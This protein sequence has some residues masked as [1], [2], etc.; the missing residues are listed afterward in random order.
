MSGSPPRLKFLILSLVVLALL[1]LSL[2][3]LLE[4]RPGGVVCGD[5]PLCYGRFLPV[6][7]QE[8]FHEMAHRLLAALLVVGTI[9]LGW[10]ARELSPRQ[11][12]MPLFWVVVQA[13]L[14][15][16][17]FS[18]R[19]PTVVTLLHLMLVPVFWYSL[20][21]LYYSLGTRPSHSF[22][23]HTK[24]IPLIMIVLV[25]F[26]FFLG[27][28]LQKTGASADILSG[29]ARALL[30]S[31]RWWAILTA[32]SICG[33]WVWL[34][35]QRYSFRLALVPIIALLQLTGGWLWREGTIGTVVHLALAGLLMISLL[36]S[37][38]S[39]RTEEAA[40]APGWLGD[41]LLLTK[42]RL[43]LLVMATVM[44]GMLLAPFQLTFLATLAVFLGITLQAMG[45]CALNCHLEREVDAL[46]E[47]TR[48]RPL[49]AGRM[50]PLTALI[51]GWA[52][53]LLGTVLIIL[54]SNSLTA[55]I[56]VT[57][58]LIYLYFYTPLK[59]RSPWA[60]V[61]G[62]VPG[63]LPPLMGWTAVTGEVSG[64]GMYLF[65]FLF[66]W[67][68]PHFLAIAV[69]RQ[70][71]YSNAQ[72]ITFF[73]QRGALFTKK[74]IL[75][76]TTILGALGFWSYGISGGSAAYR[77]ITLFLGGVFFGVALQGWL[78]RDEGEAFRRW[79]RVYF[80]CTIFYLP[81]QLAT[82]FLV[83]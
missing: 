47:R 8:V 71:D 34:L 19:L 55:F 1:Q 48:I 39:L 27:G 9:W 3:G 13:G 67:Q 37:W 36:S 17:T 24:D 21:E 40:P 4:A 52:L 10:G 31:H 56:G 5:W 77:L 23:R 61:V 76:F 41:F 26:Q 74:W 25:A 72:I 80:L 18:Q 62:A 64:L 6:P 16:I 65:F 66:V 81:L 59:Q 46:M 14:G 78:M 70:D 51:I 22:S 83:R 58:V 79:A 35:R 68:L 50:R 75:I 73:E 7:G 63:A 32:I 11:A 60:L 20:L 45:A 33:G 2:G 54:F 15:W 44:V 29:P 82:L 57:T 49:P 53:V 28:V 38:I 43:G 12:W 30:Q 69:Y 42:M